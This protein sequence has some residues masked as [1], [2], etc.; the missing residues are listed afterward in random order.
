MGKQDEKY[1]VYTDTGGT[2]SDAVIVRPDGTFVNGKASTT[3]DDLEQCFFNCVESGAKSMGMSVEEVLSQTEILGYGTTAGTNAILTRQ[4]APDLGL[5]ITKGFEDTTIIGRSMG[6]WAG[7]H[8]IQSIHVPTTDYPEPLIP[9]TRIKGVTERV[10]SAGDVIIPLYEKEVRQAVQEF[11]DAGVHGICVVLLWSFLNNSHEL[12]VKEI[13][14]EMAPDMAMSISSEV[15]PLI[16]E[17]SRANSTVV[18]LYIGTA[19]RKLLVRIKDRLA[20]AGYKK[21]LLV[22]QAAGGLSRSEVVKPVSTLHSGP[23]GGLVGVRFWKNQCGW[24]NVIGSDVGGTSFDV[25]I[26]PKEGSPYIREPVV[27]RFA[28]SNPMMEIIS[29]GAGGGTIA[30]VDKLTNLLRV[31]P[32][33]AGAKPGPVCYSRGGTEPTV[34]DADVVLGRIDPDYFL[35]GTMNL[36]KAAAEKAMKEKIADPMGI[37]VE[38][39]A[40]DICEIIDQ[41][42]GDTLASTIRQRGLNPAEF[43]VFGFGG[44]GPAHCAGYTAG[45]GY[46]RVVVTPFASTF[47][48]YGASTSD[49]LHRY[50][51]S[52]F[53]VMPGLPY[54]VTTGYFTV[55]EIPEEKKE[56]IERY[57]GICQHL[58]DGAYKDMADEGFKKSDISISYVLEIRYGGQLYE[59]MTRPDKILI[60]SVEDL[61][62]ILQ[63]FENE[64][65][66]LFSE[67][68]MY[69]GGGIEIYNIVVEASAS[70]MKPVPSKFPKN[71][72]DPKKAFKGTRKVYFKVGDERKWIDT[73]I[74]EMNSLEHGN[75]VD[76]PAIIEHVDTT[77]V[78]LPDLVVAVDEY[79]HM[80]M[81]DK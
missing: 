11:I 34:T 23:V 10:D 80:I 36:D 73:S 4:G 24:D 31:G 61:N 44:A 48:A 47:S 13:I 14:E 30:Y 68:A 18:N 59:V 1:I 62:H 20:D 63:T 45:I 41:T 78:V 22:M 7:I 74:Y 69:P 66:R 79:H 3:P 55:T 2:F 75:V 70:V 43:T 32:M 52:P 56:V 57:N 76:G 16:R 6:R 5:I 8:P 27:A 81:T 39:A 9:R 40:L 19:L 37:S 50:E 26:L 67:G 49:V 65:A 77:F 53:T 51:S 17:C 54:D 12:R 58:I 35:G 72:P 28:I 21:P 64:Y 71:G 46:E 42:M 38:D 29:I 25:S 33:S 60:D 15:S